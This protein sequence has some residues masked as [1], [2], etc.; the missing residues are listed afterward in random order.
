MTSRMTENIRPSGNASM[1]TAPSSRS[2]AESQTSPEPRLIGG[3]YQVLR[4]LKTVADSESLLA[5]DRVQGTSVVV[6]M[7]SAASFSPSVKMRL[8]HEAHVLSKNEKGNVYSAPRL[9]FRRRSDLFRCAIHRRDH[10]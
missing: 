9:W 5:F 10:A 4:A 3:R 8:E 2:L 1:T 7:A 6:R